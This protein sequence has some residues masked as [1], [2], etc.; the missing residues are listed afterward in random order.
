MSAGAIIVMILGI[1]V[2]WGG[3][4]VSIWNTVRKSKKV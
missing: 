2:I 4:C 1:L 3:L